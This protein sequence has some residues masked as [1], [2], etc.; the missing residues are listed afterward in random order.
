M[1]P[2]VIILAVLLHYT[3][4]VM[5]LIDPAAANTTP[6]H[7]LTV[8]LQGVAPTAAGCITVALLASF[9]LVGHFHRPSLALLL[10]LPQQ[11]FLVAS[12]TGAIMAVARGAYTDG[13]QRPELFILAGQL[14]PILLAP[15][16]TLAVLDSQGVLGRLRR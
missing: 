6:L 10:L 14:L 7:T 16:Y 2:W 11:A 9:R 15:I 12:A 1:W 3:W 8:L 5:L 4:G 13:V